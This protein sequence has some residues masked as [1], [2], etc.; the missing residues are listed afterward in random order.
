MANN[1]S[2]RFRIPF[3][4]ENAESWYATFKDMLEN[5]DARMFAN[6]EH[7]TPIL[8]EMP[9]VEIIDLG[10]G[11]Y[12]FHP[13]ARA[14][15]LSR[16]LHV[17]VEVAARPPVALIPGAILG[18]RLQSGAVGPQ[19]VV[20]EVWNTGLDIDADMVPFGYVNADGSVTWFNGSVLPVGVVLPLFGGAGGGG[21]GGPMWTGV[22]EYWIDSTNGS[23]APD[24]D[25]GS[26]NN[27]FKTLDVAVAAVQPPTVAEEA[28]RIVVFHVASGI[29]PEDVALPPY[30]FAYAF[31]FTSGVIMGG[32]LTW[33]VDTDLWSTWGMSLNQYVPTLGIDGGVAS[34]FAG[35]MIVKREGSVAGPSGLTKTLALQNLYLRGTVFQ[36]P[37]GNVDRPTGALL[38]GVVNCFGYG[39][40]TW[41]QTAGEGFGTPDWKRNTVYLGTQNSVLYGDA[42]GDITIGGCYDSTFGQI[43]DATPDT[44]SIVE[45]QAGYGGLPGFVNCLFTSGPVIG[46]ALSA[47]PVHPYSV[48]SSRYVRFDANSYAR[49]AKIGLALQGFAAAPSAGDPLG[50]VLTDKAWGV[51][52]DTKDLLGHVL[53]EDYDAQ[54]VAAR[55]DWLEGTRLD[56]GVLY[57]C[58]VDPSGGDDSNDGLTAL[59]PLLTVPMALRKIGKRPLR[60]AVRI[61]LLGGGADVL[62]DCIPIILEG[63]GS[64]MVIGDV[65]PVLLETLEYVST[66][67]A[68]GS[69]NGYGGLRLTFTVGGGSPGWSDDGLMGQFL[70]FG[71][72]SDRAGQAIPVARNGSDWI[73]VADAG[74]GA[75]GPEDYLVDPGVT[76][77]Q[78]Y[79]VRV[80]IDQRTDAR[81]YAAAQSE[82]RDARVVFANL[83]VVFGAPS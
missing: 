2:P 65:A 56:E 55:L 69:V 42:Y 76:V 20:W 53:R 49:A 52:V 23:N 54:R 37:S 47:H 22:E 3:P 15:F 75:V 19:S 16:T 64:F 6:L 31:Q 21:A 66:A 57:E 82:M 62:P 43:G 5:L 83:K 80:V 4:K 51:G 78:S 26:Q 70:V 46:S 10:G 50:Y 68:G 74:I 41:L 27:P 61:H 14:V 44:E 63:E 1:E 38:L 72:G 32:D 35:D 7:L 73:E 28:Q 67:P 13:H 30:R 24:P 9:D 36:Q 33:R 11:V 45:S 18:A 12:E 58:Y 40:T 79:P 39:G 48:P 25:R 34:I 59:T 8:V 29:Y 71:A 17:E 81:G 77:Q 60:N